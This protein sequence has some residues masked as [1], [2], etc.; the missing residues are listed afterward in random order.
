MKPVFFYLLF[1]DFKRPLVVSK[2]FVKRSSRILLC[3][4]L[5][6]WSN[7]LEAVQTL[8]ILRFYEHANFMNNGAVL[9]LE[10]VKYELEKAGKHFKLP[11]L[12]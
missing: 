2:S 1:Q 6:I 7:L 9:N 4:P 12:I 10:L 11:V 3:C 5:Q 8:R